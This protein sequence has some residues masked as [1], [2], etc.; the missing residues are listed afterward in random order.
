VNEEA[1]RAVHEA[2]REYLAEDEI[3][4]CWVLTVEVARSDGNHLIHRAGGGFDGT[5]NPMAWTALGMLEAAVRTA[6]D[7]VADSTEDA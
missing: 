6:A 2:T 1:Q 4:V 7:Q 3:P 5:E